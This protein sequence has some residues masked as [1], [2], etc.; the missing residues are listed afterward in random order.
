MAPPDLWD[1]GRAVPPLISSAPP[2]IADVVLMI[3][4]LSY[5]VGAQLVAQPHSSKFP[6]W[7]EAARIVFSFTSNSAAAERVFSLLKIFFTD[8]YCSPA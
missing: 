3:E 8:A 4:L 6:A 2:W 7:A 5:K 1:L